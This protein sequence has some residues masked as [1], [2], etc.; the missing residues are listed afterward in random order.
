MQFSS[1]TDTLFIGLSRPV[2]PGGAGGAIASPDQLTLSQ[3]EG[4]DYANQIT[5]ATGTP[6]FSDFP[7]ALK[8]ILGMIQQ[9]TVLK[10]TF[11]FYCFIARLRLV[12]SNNL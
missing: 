3:L 6:V 5:S 7:T 8:Y 10:N 4:V 11:D 9:K 2:V 12:T 1:I